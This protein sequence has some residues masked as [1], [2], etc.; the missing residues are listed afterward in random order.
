MTGFFI[1][2]FE[3]I[4]LKCITE[5]MAKLAKNGV[6]DENMDPSKKA[7]EIFYMGPYCSRFI[8]N[9]KTK[10]DV[11]WKESNDESLSR[12]P[13]LWTIKKKFKE[14]ENVIF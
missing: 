10:I 14:R 8:E 7:P 1:D 13:P 3:Y 9:Y 11:L 2:K 5:E 12:G 6:I 4:P